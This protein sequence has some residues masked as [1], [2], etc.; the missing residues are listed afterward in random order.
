MIRKRCLIIWIITWIKKFS[1]FKENS[2]ACWNSNRYIDSEEFKYIT[3]NSERKTECHKSILDKKIVYPIVKDKIER[4]KNNGE[5][6]TMDIWMNKTSIESI[7]KNI[8]D[9]S[10]II[11]SRK[12]VIKEISADVNFSGV[13]GQMA[14]SKVMD[15]ISL[16]PIHLKEIIDVINSHD[17]VHSHFY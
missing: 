7:C 15:S 4:E 13:I 14:Q 12:R 16:D 11:D 2:I 8:V 9:N 3:K 6:L 10:K 1:I 5:N 17:H